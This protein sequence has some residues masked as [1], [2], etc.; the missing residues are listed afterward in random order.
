MHPVPKRYYAQVQL[1][2]LGSDCLEARMDQAPGGHA[3]PGLALEP[4]LSRSDLIGLVMGGYF[5]SPVPSTVPL[6]ICT[7]VDLASAGLGISTS[8]TPFSGSRP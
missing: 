6:P 8:R 1:G 7:R 3:I 5:C 2:G 4:E